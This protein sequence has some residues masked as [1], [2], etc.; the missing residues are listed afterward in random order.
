MNWFSKHILSHDDLELLS[1]KIADAESRTSGEI[2]LVLR[3]RRQWKERGIPLHDL[4]LHEFHR[5]GMEKTKE[6]TGVLILLLLSERAFQI[7]ADEGIYARVADGT[8]ERIAAAMTAHFRQKNYT[9]GLSEAV[10][11]VGKEL[12]AHFPRKTD[13]TDQ[14]PNDVIE[15]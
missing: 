13:D 11:A 4:A 1:R 12:A 3:H 10:A 7:I 5:L 14:L 15:R 6:R 2:R 8:W 9:K